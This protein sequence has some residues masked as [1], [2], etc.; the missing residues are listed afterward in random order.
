MISTK[1]ESVILSFLLSV[2]VFL[3]L[4][5]PITTEPGIKKDQETGWSVDE[6]VLE[7]QKELLEEARDSM[8]AV[9]P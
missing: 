2:M 4:G 3:F 5:C 1:L 8:E 6:E 9:R 7:E